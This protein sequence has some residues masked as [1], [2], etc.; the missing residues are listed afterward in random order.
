MIRIV[1]NDAPNL[2]HCKM[3]CD[4]KLHD[5]LDDYEVTS[6]LNNHS[7]TL[8]IGKPKSGK[9][10]LL[11]SFFKSKKL[12]NKV[13]DRIFIMQPSASRASMKD[14]LFNKLPEDQIYE[15]LNLQNL[16]EIE[17]KLTPDGNNV[18]LIDDMSAYLK[19]KNNLKKLKQLVFNRRHLHLS[20]FFLVQ[21]WFSVP[22]EIRKL[23]S[24][25]F[26]FKVSKNEMSVIWDEVIE[27]STDLVLPIV[28]LVYDQ[29]YQWLFINTDSQRMFKCFDELVFD[30]EN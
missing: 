24:N 28:K 6:F 11:Y 27:H 15:E 29:P 4:T 21:T 23:F 5:K 25:I 7:T 26:V 3:I 18:L 12:M 16:T 1:E 2:P 10:S 14:Q 22:K 20:I 8:F 30:E 13:F 9:T 19:D 17:S